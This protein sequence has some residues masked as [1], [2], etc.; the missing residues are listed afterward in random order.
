V[1]PEG[2]DALIDAVNRGDDHGTVAALVKDG[3]YVVS[4]TGSTDV[5][6]SAPAKSEERT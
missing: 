3:G 2:I 1:R 5:E 6:A 4:T